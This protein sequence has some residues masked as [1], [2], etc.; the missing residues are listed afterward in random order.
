MPPNGNGDGRVEAEGEFTLYDSFWEKLK[1][2]IGEASFEAIVEH[3]QE[4]KTVL[5]EDIALG[6]WHAVLNFELT[7]ERVNES[8]DVSKPGNI[9]L[10]ISLAGTAQVRLDSPTNQSWDLVEYQPIKLNYEQLFLSNVAQ[11]GES[12]RLLIGRGDFTFPQQAAAGM[13]GKA[14]VASTI[15][16]PITFLQTYN[17]PWFDALNYGRVVVVCYTTGGAAANR[18]RVEQSIDQAQ[19]DYFTNYVV[20]AGVGFAASVEVVARYV[21][22]AYVH[23]GGAVRMVAMARPQ[24]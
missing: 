3:L 11:A 19:V 20:N 2:M 8:I 23:A 16:T 15:V 7:A 17:Y 12:L 4:L 24:P 14:I 6:D 1:D 21:R 10:P 13:S 18:L 22:I 5:L 9:I